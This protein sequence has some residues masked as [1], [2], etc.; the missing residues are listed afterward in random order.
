MIARNWKW[1]K[2]REMITLRYIH[3][4]KYMQSFRIFFKSYFMTREIATLKFK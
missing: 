3:I 2:H 1:P 4:L